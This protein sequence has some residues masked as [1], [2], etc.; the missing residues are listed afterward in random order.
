M[1]GLY[2]GLLPKLLQSVLTAA[3][4]FAAQRRIYELIKRVR[5][6]LLGRS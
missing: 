4:M 6:I 5:E 3:F 2:A 1:A